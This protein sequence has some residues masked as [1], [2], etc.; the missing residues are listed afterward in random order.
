MNAV[1]EKEEKRI[2]YFDV[3]N[4]L[5]CICVIGMHCNGLVH[6]FSDTAVWRQSLLV[7][8]LAYWAVPAF[9]MI[10]GATLMRY[11]TRY[12]TGEFLK[13]RLLAAPV[14]YMLALTAVKLLQRIPVVG[15]YL[16]P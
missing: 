2:V 8:V 9:F 1:G 3:L 15:K 4:V 11:R 13:R 6:E 5:A 16:F 14:V 10:S 7:D 12:S